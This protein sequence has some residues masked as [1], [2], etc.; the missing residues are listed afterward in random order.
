MTQTTSV[1]TIGNRLCTVIR[2]PF[3]PEWVREQL[4]M[5][6]PV[7]VDLG[8]NVYDAIYGI[9]D[10]RAL[11]YNASD[12][13]HLDNIRYTLAILPALKR[14]PTPYDARLLHRYEAENL[15]VAGVAYNITDD[16]LRI[17]RHVECGNTVEITHAI[18]NGE[19]CEVAIIEKEGE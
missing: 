13:V 9:K 17:L 10:S 18:M 19:R 5:G 14:Y 3:D 4:T 8:N 7:M 11:L 6:M 16:G 1:E 15:R 12:T 2:K